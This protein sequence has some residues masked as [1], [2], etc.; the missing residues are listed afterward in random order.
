MSESREP[1]QK[2][3]P[4]QEAFSSFHLRSFYHSL[5][6][7]LSTSMSFPILKILKLGIVEFY[8]NQKPGTSS[9]GPSLFISFLECLLECPGRAVK[10]GYT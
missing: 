7:A 2:T 9:D 10:G 4:F 3:Q 1:C 6:L 5:G 8:R